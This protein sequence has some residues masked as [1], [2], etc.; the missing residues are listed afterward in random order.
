MCK[1]YRRTGV[2]EVVA[3]VRLREGLSGSQGEPRGRCAGELFR[4]FVV[5]SDA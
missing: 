3:R 5:P 4:L 1:Y 2:H